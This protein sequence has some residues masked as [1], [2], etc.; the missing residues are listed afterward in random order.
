MRDGRDT[1]RPN[2]PATEADSVEHREDMLDEALEGSFPASDP[3]SSS[4][5][6]A[7]DETRA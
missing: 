7:P 3:P 5:T 1:A 6:L 4:A 2:G